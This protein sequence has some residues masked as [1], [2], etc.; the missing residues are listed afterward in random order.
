MDCGCPE[1][2]TRPSVLLLTAAVLPGGCATNNAV[3]EARKWCEEFGCSQYDLVKMPAYAKY[4]DAEVMPEESFR[5]SRKAL[6]GSTN[7]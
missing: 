6:V 7:G 3:L 4:F 1:F 5:P 2:A